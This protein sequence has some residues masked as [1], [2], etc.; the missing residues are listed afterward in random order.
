MSFH[1]QGIMAPMTKSGGKA[2]AG[3]SPPGRERQLMRRTV[4]G[5]EDDGHRLAFDLSQA[6]EP[7]KRDVDSTSEGSLMDLGD[8]AGAWRES[9]KLPVHFLYRALR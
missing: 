8:L 1:P 6:R 2:A 9:R 4:N 3:G 5:H 7:R